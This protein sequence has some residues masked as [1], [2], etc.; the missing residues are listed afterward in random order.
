M[1][2]KNPLEIS[3]SHSSAAESADLKKACL[4]FFCLATTH[5]PMSVL[6]LSPYHCTFLVGLPVYTGGLQRFVWAML[7]TMSRSHH[8]HIIQFIFADQ[9]IKF[10]WTLSNYF[11]LSFYA[12]MHFL[13]FKIKLIEH[14]TI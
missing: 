13:T 11:Q 2:F 3:S 9:D 10:G 7:S 6:I 5:S 14:L 12:V 8:C 1:Y 4:N